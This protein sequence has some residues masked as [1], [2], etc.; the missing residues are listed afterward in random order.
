MA[1]TTPKTWASGPLV[2]ADLNTVRDQLVWLKAALLYHGIDSDTVLGQLK[3]A[4]YDCSVYRDTNQ[5][6]VSA[7]TTTIQFP[8]EYKDP[9]AM[10]S[11]GTNTQRITIPSG[12]DGDYLVGY[13]LEFG[14]NGTGDRIGG[15]AVNGSNVDWGGM[16]VPAAG[17]GGGTELSTSTLWHDATAGDYLTLVARQGSGSSLAVTYANLW[18]ARLFAA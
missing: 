13:T 10:H 6:L 7:T 16:E 15:F 11:T 4:A 8:S 18:V 9:E 1:W 14:A 12:G 17:A 3:G 5:S 2:A